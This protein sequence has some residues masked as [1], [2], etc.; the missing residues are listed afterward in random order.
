MATPSHKK[1]SAMSGFVTVLGVAGIYFALQL[2][3]LPAAGIPT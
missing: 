1:G 3:I 2:W